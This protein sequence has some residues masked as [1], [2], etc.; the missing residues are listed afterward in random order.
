[1]DFSLVSKAIIDFI[2]KQ[3]E[4]RKI[5]GG[6]VIGISGGID[7]TVLAYLA[8][9]ALGKNKVLGVILPDSEITPENDIKDAVEV[10]ARLGIEYKLLYINEPKNRFLQLLQ[11]QEDELLIGNLVARIRMCILYYHAGLMSSIVLGS[12][13][14]TELQLGYFTKYGDGA[15]DLLPIGDLYKTQLVE[16]ARFLQIPANIID[17]K[18]SARLWREQITEEELGLPFTQLDRILQFLNG[19]GNLSIGS[20]KLLNEF[21][22]IS[23]DK[24]RN[25]QVLLQKNYHKLSFPLI[26]KL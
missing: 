3:I 9:K 17:K 4:S 2:K 24:I 23:S 5:E 13:N 22:E 20:E 18:S 19:S 14:K 21:S 25:V 26:C 10:C 12:S 16:L 7:S 11:H 1:M 6:T 8:T 15:S